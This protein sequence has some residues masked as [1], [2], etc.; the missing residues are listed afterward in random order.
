MQ[1]GISEQQWLAYVDETGDNAERTRIDAH[2]RGCPECGRLALD[3]KAWR[4]LLTQEAARSRVAVQLD[5]TDLD[6]LLAGC[7][8]RMRGG[9]RWTLA[10]AMM[11]MLSLLEPL[12]GLGV[13]RVTRDLAMQRSGG[14]WKLFVASLSET[15]A[16]VC[17]SAA[18][19]LVSRAGQCMLVQG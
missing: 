1:H 7:M 8:D 10:E 2:T 6:S 3:L 16:S 5:G 12:C 18:G 19:L 9:S 13:A 17:G 4:G 14:N 11:L 15:I